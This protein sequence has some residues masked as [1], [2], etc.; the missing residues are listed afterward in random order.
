MRLIAVFAVALLLAACSPNRLETE[1]EGGSA[2]THGFSTAVVSRSEESWRIVFT[3]KAN[4]GTPELVEIG[5][6]RVFE[7]GAAYI[8]GRDGVSLIVERAGEGPFTYHL[9]TVVVQ[10]FDPEKGTIRGIYQARR[11]PGVRNVGEVE[12]EG[13]RRIEG[14]FELRFDPLSS[15]PTRE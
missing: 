4:W 5:L 2:R 8:P 9:G 12:P 6:P 3:R 7:V 10:E 1:Y 11:V 13:I 14:R 15:A